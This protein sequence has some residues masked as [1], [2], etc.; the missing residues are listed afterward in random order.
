MFFVFSLVLREIFLK[1][2]SFLIN[3]LKTAILNYFSS[4]LFCI[5]YCI[6]CRLLEQE[7]TDHKD[8]K[9]TWRKANEQFLEQQMALSWEIEK[10]R[11]LL[12]PAQNERL[13]KEYRQMQTRPAHA[14]KTPTGHSQAGG[15]SN[16]DLIKFDDSPKKDKISKQ[17]SVDPNDVHLIEVFKA[18]YFCDNFKTVSISNINITEILFCRSKR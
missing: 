15:N 5:I 3:I 11:E 13:S 2:S 4:S 6:V 9:E 14:V 7:K 16:D 1:A 10:M 17:S 18:Y 8:L 12:T